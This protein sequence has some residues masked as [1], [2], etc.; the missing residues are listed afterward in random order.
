MLKVKEKKLSENVI[1]FKSVLGLFFFYVLHDYLQERAFR[2]PRFHFGWVMTVLELGVFAILSASIGEGVAKKIPSRRHYFWFGALTLVLGISQGAGFASLSYVTFPVKVS[3]KS[4]KLIP[5][6]L[7]GLLLTGRRYSMSD[8]FSA[9]CMCLSLV[10]LSLA[11]KSGHTGKST[12]T[13]VLLLITST[14][15]DAIVP[16]IQERIM[17]KLKVRLPDM[18]FWTNSASCILVLVFTALSGELF[19]A[20]RLFLE[21]PFALGLLIVQAAFGYCGLRCYLHLVKTGGAA[22]GVVCTT[23]RKL[24]TLVLSFIAF[25]K[26]FTTL[27][28][29]GLI[30]LGVGIVSVV[31][32]KV[33]TKKRRRKKV[34]RV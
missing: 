15:S 27:H 34:Q 20:I 14:F 26:P 29:L 31:S 1:P 30:L 11:E 19:L 22:L 7:F 6:M 25:K 10:V 28:L 2:N 32:K 3:F 33:R 4:C 16:N 5:T 9:V 13:G 21:E 24:I 18:V 23:C 17:V 8:Y 12:L